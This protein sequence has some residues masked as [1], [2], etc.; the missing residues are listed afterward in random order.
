MKF[1][2]SSL[3]LLSANIV[4]GKFIINF[5]E[6]PKVSYDLGQYKECFIDMNNPTPNEDFDYDSETHDSFCKIFNSSKCKKFFKDPKKYLKGISNSKDYEKIKTDIK[7]KKAYLDFACLVDKKKDGNKK[8]CPLIRKYLDSSI[9]NDNYLGVPKWRK[10]LRENCDSV[11]CS[12]ALYNY[13]KTYYD[14]IK[15][16]GGKE[17]AKEYKYGVDYQKQ[18]IKNAKALEKAKKN[19]TTD[20][21]EEYEEPTPTESVVETPLSIYYNVTSK[22]NECVKEIDTIMSLNELKDFCVTINSSNCKKFYK[23][24]K[25]YISDVSGDDY[26]IALADIERIKMQFKYACSSYSEN[27]TYS[28]EYLE[29]FEDEEIIGEYLNFT[30]IDKD[31]ESFHVFQQSF[32]PMIERKIDENAGRRI[33]HHTLKEQPHRNCRY[34][35]CA[36]GE[37]EYSVAAYKYYQL[38]N[39]KEAM[40]DFLY[41]IETNQECMDLDYILRTFIF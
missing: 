33:G 2:E 25:R 41:D 39:D 12:E 19:K 30:I 1:L 7:M 32:C 37:Y 18:C 16:L 26:T 9:Y 17:V 8:Y 20:K 24:P 34:E 21:D 15:K 4:L 10:A 14:G 29:E 35:E 13:Y 28:I 3:I 5:P 31:D 40:E 11:E 36:K 27:E 6:L 38:I 22:Y 23:N